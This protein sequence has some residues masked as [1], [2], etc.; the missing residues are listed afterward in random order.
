MYPI[1]EQKTGLFVKFDKQ[2]CFILCL[3]VILAKER[4]P[5]FFGDTNNADAQPSASSTR[6]L[7]RQVISLGVDD[8]AATQYGIG[9]VEG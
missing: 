3:M 9:A 8:H 5:L 6:R 4:I 7:R 2:A 1:T